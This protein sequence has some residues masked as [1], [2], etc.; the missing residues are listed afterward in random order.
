MPRQRFADYA[1]S[2]DLLGVR[3]G[4]FNKR[5]AAA[6]RLGPRAYA[7]RLPAP[8]QRYRPKGSA[9]GMLPPR[10]RGSNLSARRTYPSLR[11]HS[12]MRRRGLELIPCFELFS[13][14]GGNSRRATELA[15]MFA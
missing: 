3:F 5:G 9:R 6:A 12:A 10:E 13:A 4:R 2:F 8:R 7:G 15:D 11:V 1:F 14:S